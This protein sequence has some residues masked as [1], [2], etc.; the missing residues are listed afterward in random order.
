MWLGRQMKVQHLD[1]Q[2]LTLL[3]L[4]QIVQTACCSMEWT[5]PV[6][7][8]RRVQ[9]LCTWDRYTQRG[10]TAVLQVNTDQC[11]VDIFKDL[12]WVLYPVDKGTLNI[13]SPVGTVHAE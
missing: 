12:I 3:Y 8:R 13:I 5:L 2:Q 11:D 1:M 6:R 10:L 9:C 7:H 4:T